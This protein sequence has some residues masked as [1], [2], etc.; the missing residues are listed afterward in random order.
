MTGVFLV[1]KTAAR[2]TADSAALKLKII[3]C[4][5]GIITDG[6]VA[7]FMRRTVRTGSRGRLRADLVRY[8][9]VQCAMT[10]ISC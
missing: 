2:M 1:Q 8:R 10:V 3:P 6:A 7:R 5:I 4:A 9:D